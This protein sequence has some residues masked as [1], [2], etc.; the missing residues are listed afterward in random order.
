MKV[1]QFYRLDTN[2]N[3]HSFFSVYT[4]YVLYSNPSFDSR[5]VKREDSTNKNGTGVDRLDDEEGKKPII[6][7]SQPVYS[8]SCIRGCLL[9]VEQHQC[10]GKTCGR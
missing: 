5:D 8:L 7:R 2:K 3:Y 6:C 10:S 9:I 4:V 1:S